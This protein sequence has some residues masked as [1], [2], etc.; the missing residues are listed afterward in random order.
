MNRQNDAL[1]Y[2]LR[3][4]LLDL[5]YTL[6]FLTRGDQILMLHRRK[7]PNQGLWNG[8]GGHIE[9]GEAPLACA[10]REIK[11][12]TG[13]IIEDLRFH[14]LLTWEGYETPAGGLYIFSG[15]APS[16]GEAI[17]DDE[18]ELAWKAREWVFSNPQVV[19]NIHIMGPAVFNGDPPRVYHFHY[20]DSSIER[21][22]FRDLPPDLNI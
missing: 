18:G 17:G 9:A 6:I 10:L 21:Y 22:E 3:M 4:D 14:G 16:T 12:E 13:F 11:E 20:L 19:S 15:E 1:R 8:I 5:R 7:P 2:N